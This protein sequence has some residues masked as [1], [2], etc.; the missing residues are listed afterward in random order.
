MGFGLLFLG[1][2][3]PLAPLP[4]LLAL[5]DCIG[6]V[7]MLVALSKLSP[8]SK[9]FKFAGYILYFMLALSLTTLFIES[10]VFINE[11]ITPLTVFKSPGDIINTLSFSQLVCNLAFHYFLF[12]ALIDIAS[13][14]ENKK[15]VR[16][17]K[18]NRIITLI[19][20]IYAVIIAL[21]LGFPKEIFQYLAYINNIAYYPV[22]ILNAIQIFSCYMWIC[23]EGDEDMP[24]PEKS[25]FKNKGGRSKNQSK[26]GE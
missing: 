9:N 25:L 12:Q 7:F 3:L 22:F 14:V 10:T 18:R 21:P 5:P 24:A 19:Y 1:Y 8:H 17:C 16:K 4:Y 15:I 11:F 23:Y 26:K 2:T 13:F 20:L 6:F